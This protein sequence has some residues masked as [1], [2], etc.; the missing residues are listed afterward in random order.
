MGAHTN[1]W[2]ARDIAHATAPY[3]ALTQTR[4][5]IEEVSR[6][7][8]AEM[9]SNISISP[10]PEKEGEV[11]VYTGQKGIR[12]RLTGNLIDRALTERRGLPDLTLLIM[13]FGKKT[14]DELFDEATRDLSR[15]LTRKR[16]SLDF[17][18]MIN[19]R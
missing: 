19:R 16:F 12:R 13:R 8:L 9:D 6:S 7:A 10:G 3:H 5:E 17:L 18:D 4:L 15:P 11:T 2:I 1:L 14:P